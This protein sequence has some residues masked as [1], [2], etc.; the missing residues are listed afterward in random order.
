MPFIADIDASTRAH[1]E[2]FHPEMVQ[3]ALRLGILKARAAID[4]CAGGSK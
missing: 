3:D 4:I 1:L 2:R